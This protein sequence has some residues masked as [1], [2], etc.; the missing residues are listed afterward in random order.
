VRAVGGVLTGLFL[1]GAAL[2]V[3]GCDEYRKNEFPGYMEADLAL[4]G[5]EQGG[6]VETLTVK[7]GDSVEKAAPIFTL[8]ST[9]QEAEVAASR[10]R[11]TEAEARLAD[12]RQQTQRPSEIDVLEASLAQAKAM[13]VQSNLNLDRTR[14]LFGKNW[15]SKAQLDEATAQHDR[16]EAAVA[17][18]ERRI[19][20]AKLPNRSDLIDA[21]AASVEA[22][23][24]SLEQGE[25]GLAKRKVLAPAPGTIEEVY[26]RPGEVVNAGQAVVALLP[27]GNLKVRFFVQEP[28]RAS[29]HVDQTIVVTCD[30]CTGELTAKISFIAREAEFT[31]PVIFSREQREKLVFLIEARPSEATAKL[32]AGQPVTVS[33][34]A[35]EPRIVQR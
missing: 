23:R 1:I 5:S 9:E 15:V 10:A 12:A 26:F 8:E 21:L 11:V 13:L 30:G 6:R 27:P 29:L 24:H 3:S 19:T 25:K 18:A 28:V 17:E 22:A 31:P 34:G 16:N 14:T 2:F 4:V 20:A 7:E 32:T 33:I 35:A